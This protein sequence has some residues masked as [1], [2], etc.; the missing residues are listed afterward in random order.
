MPHGRACTYTPLSD[1]TTQIKVANTCWETRTENLRTKGDN[2]YFEMKAI[3]KRPTDLTPQTS[4]KSLRNGGDSF[5]CL[6][7]LMNTLCQ[8]IFTTEIVSLW[9]RRFNIFWFVI[10]LPVTCR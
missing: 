5:Q 6:R 10:P 4:G 8:N 7:R 2:E 9:L 1:N 3:L